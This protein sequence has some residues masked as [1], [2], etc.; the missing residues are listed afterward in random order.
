M[1]QMVT[2]VDKCIHCNYFGLSLALE[3]KNPVR[4]CNGTQYLIGL[5][6]S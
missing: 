5:T 3:D 4:F 1:S 2:V 6:V